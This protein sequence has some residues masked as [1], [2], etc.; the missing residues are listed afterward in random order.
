MLPLSTVTAHKTME[1]KKKQS[2]SVESDKL[3][4]MLELANLVKEIARAGQPSKGNKELAKHPV[5]KSADRV[6]NGLK[7]ANCEIEYYLKPYRTEIYPKNREII[8]KSKADPEWL[9]EVLINAYLGNPKLNI[10]LCISM[11]M[12]TAFKMRKAIETKYKNIN[13]REEALLGLHGTYVYMLYYKFLVVIVDA[14]GEDHR[15]VTRLRSI[16]E[17]VK[18]LCPINSDD[19]DGSGEESGEGKSLGKTVSS[20]SG[21]KKSTKEIE[22]TVGSIIGNTDAINKMKNVMEKINKSGKSNPLEDDETIIEA[23]RE[24]GPMFRDMFE[25]INKDMKGDEESSSGSEESE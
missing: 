12:N 5:I 16:I 19:S 17:K 20:L 7:S 24:V 3:S 14:L 23:V 13:D 18:D 6:I 1:P 21:D 15:D 9:T 2:S 8:L 10:C 22:K 11:A 4:H 25:N